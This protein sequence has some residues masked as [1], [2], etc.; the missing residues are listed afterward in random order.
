MQLEQFVEQ[1]EGTEQVE[2]QALVEENQNGG[3][4]KAIR[5]RLA[6]EVLKRLGEKP[7]PGPV[8]DRYTKLYPPPQSA[9]GD[10][11]LP[12]AEMKPLEDYPQALVQPMAELQKSKDAASTHKALL[13]LGEALLVYL[14][15]I[16]FGEYRKSWPL[17][18][19]IEA[20]FYKSA[21]RKPS[22]GVFLGF[23][24]RLIKAEG[25]SILDHLCHKKAQFNA[26]YEY[27]LVYD[28]LSQVINQGAGRQLSPGGR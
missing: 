7:N 10:W 8:I 1:L 18:E 2:Y 14:T 11:A 6:R 22:F 25:E 24:R 15:G 12:A 23:V 16:Q 9:S 19:E 27:V 28:L 5:G 3:D 13:D 17:D 20:E 4:D 26:V 21:K